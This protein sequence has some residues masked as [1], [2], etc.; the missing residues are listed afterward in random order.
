MRSIVR[1][2]AAEAE[3]L[4]RKHVEDALAAV[5]EMEDVLPQ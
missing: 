4:M 5:I 1:R 3:R 2:D